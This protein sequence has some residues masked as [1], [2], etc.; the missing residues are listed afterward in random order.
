MDR[1][2]KDQEVEKQLGLLP[3]RRPEAHLEGQLGQEQTPSFSP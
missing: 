3:K 1:Q 2:T